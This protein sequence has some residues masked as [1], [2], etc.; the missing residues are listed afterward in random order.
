VPWLIRAAPRRG[1]LAP[2][3]SRAVWSAGSCGRAAPR[4]MDG[5]CDRPR[6]LWTSFARSAT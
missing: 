3:R 2:T 6:D 4:R 5:P 1:I